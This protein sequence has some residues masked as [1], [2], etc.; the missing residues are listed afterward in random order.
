MSNIS[1][2]HETAIVVTPATLKNQIIIRLNTLVNKA[3]GAYYPTDDMGHTKPLAVIEGY[4]IH[5]IETKGRDVYL[6]GVPNDE[7][8]A[9]NLDDDQEPYNAKE[10]YL[11]QLWEVY[12]G[13]EP[14]YQSRFNDYASFQE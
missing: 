5:G 8:I 11:E 4:E 3:G 14:L 2:S 12:L 13:C 10:F 7:N 9:I 6:M 1:R